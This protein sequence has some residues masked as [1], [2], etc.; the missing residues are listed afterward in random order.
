MRLCLRCLLALPLLA[1]LALPATACE[2]H[3]QGH[4]N[5]SDSSAEAS[6]R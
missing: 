6:Q 3:L 2:R 1:G 5:S 4:Q